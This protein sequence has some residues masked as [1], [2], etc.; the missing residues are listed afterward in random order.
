MLLVQHAQAL[1]L[2]E[3]A[4]QV[5]VVGRR[6]LAL[7]LVADPRLAAAVDEK[8]ARR[9]RDLGP[10]GGNRR[11]R[12][13]ARSTTAWR[14]SRDSATSSS[15]SA[16]AG[17]NFAMARAIW[18]A[19]AN[20]T[21]ETVGTVAPDAPQGSASEPA[22]VPCQDLVNVSRVERIAVDQLGI[23][24]AEPVVESRSDDLLVE[25]ARKPLHAKNLRSWVGQPPDEP[26][27][28]SDGV[29]GL[30]EAFEETHRPRRVDDGRPR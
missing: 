21:S 19:R 23:D 5:D 11:A 10:N 24:V 3:G 25:S 20:L 22:D 7:H 30:W 14:R 4:E 1:P 27:R 28:G 16:T 13:A 2:D 29:T 17:A 15:S 12:R 26:S 8:C 6:Q 9:Q 18:F